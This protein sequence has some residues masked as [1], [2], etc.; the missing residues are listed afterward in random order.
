MEGRAG[1]GETE[2]WEKVTDLDAPASKNETRRK[3]LLL[4]PQLQSSLCAL[5]LV[6]YWRMMSIRRSAG[7]YFLLCGRVGDAFAIVRCEVPPGHA[8]EYC[9]ER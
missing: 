3:I 8:E 1:N 4:V 2:S 9:P 6:E 7:C 5:C